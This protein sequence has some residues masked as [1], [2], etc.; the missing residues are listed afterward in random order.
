M[1]ICKVSNGCSNVLKEA[2]REHKSKVGNIDESR[3][4]LNEC[5]RNRAFE[6]DVSEAHIR[7]YI[8]N[9]LGVKRKIQSDAVLMCSVIIDIPKDYKGDQQAFFQSA[10]TNLNDFWCEGKAE[11]IIQYEVHYDEKTPHAHFAF[12][13]I[14]QNKKGDPA[15]SAKKVVNRAKLQQ[16]H[17][18]MEKQMSADLGQP[19]K[20]TLTEEEKESQDDYVDDLREF[21][22]RKADME[23]KLEKESEA[24]KAKAKEEAIAEAEAEAEEIKAKARAEASE[25]LL[26]ANEE[27]SAIKARYAGADAELERELQLLKQS[28]DDAIPKRKYHDE[29]INEQFKEFRLQK[30]AEAEERAKVA[31]LERRKALLAEKI[32]QNE[33]KWSQQGSPSRDTTLTR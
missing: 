16:F 14:T 9:D 32:K 4:H 27:A 10:L 1:H 28:I 2:R 31:E 21:K 19:I 33:Q 20:L 29:E 22:R 11:R 30:V 24:I 3:S 23:A 8:S 26:K 13:P 17:K 15:L 18:F 25:M 7:E 12:I 5:G 6:D